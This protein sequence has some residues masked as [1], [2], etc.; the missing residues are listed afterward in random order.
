MCEQFYEKNTKML[1]ERGGKIMVRN[2]VDMCEDENSRVS[3]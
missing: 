2:I 3:V 1:Q